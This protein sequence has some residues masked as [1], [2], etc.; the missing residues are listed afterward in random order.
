M[1]HILRN[2]EGRGALKCLCLIMREGYQRG[3]PND[4]ITKKIF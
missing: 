4:D 1:V 3:C 2:Q